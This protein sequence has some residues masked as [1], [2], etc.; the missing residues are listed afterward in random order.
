MSLESSKEPLFSQLK[1]QN[2]RRA[3]LLFLAAQ[4]ICMS[5]NFMSL[6]SDRFTTCRGIKTFYPPIG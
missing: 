3:R 4:P 2:P 1:T 6:P 5:P